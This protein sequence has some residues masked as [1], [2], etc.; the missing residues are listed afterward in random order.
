[1]MT[2]H[3]YQA[4]LNCN[5]SLM[6]YRACVQLPLDKDGIDSSIDTQILKIPHDLLVHLAIL[7]NE[8]KQYIG[9]HKKYRGYILLGCCAEIFK[10][11]FL[12]YVN[13]VIFEMV[14]IALND[15]Y[16]GETT[17]TALENE[18]SIW[19]Q[20]YYDRETPVIVN[21]SVNEFTPGS[22]LKLIHSHSIF[23]SHWTI[24]QPS[25]TT[26][27]P[28]LES[29]WYKKGSRFPQ[30]HRLKIITRETKGFFWSETQ[31]WRKKTIS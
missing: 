12:C 17:L 31:Q 28:T 20:M 26:S 16:L 19:R 25:S 5:Y 21:H 4:D 24:L 29:F 30:G 10:A 8:R 23:P 13:E 18:V 27:V 6:R 14:K 22:S 15:T 7:D 11:K 9:T 1:M 2:V 3:P